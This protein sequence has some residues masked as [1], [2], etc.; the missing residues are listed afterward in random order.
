MN[1]TITQIL[2]ILREFK[3]GLI[4]ILGNSIVDVILFGSFAKRDYTE[5]SDIDIDVLIIIKRWLM[6]AEENK[7]LKFV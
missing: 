2:Q 1:K 5:E 7:I 6:I 4:K 3:K